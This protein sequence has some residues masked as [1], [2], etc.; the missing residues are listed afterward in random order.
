M[1][2]L[3]EKYVEEMS[4]D[5]NSISLAIYEFYSNP[6]ISKEDHSVKKQYEI[7]KE[8]WVALINYGISTHEFQSVDPEAII[9]ARPTLELKEKALAYRDH[10]S[11]AYIE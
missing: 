4:D 9:L 11:A 7:S 6:E 1:E 2:E 8:T 3:L 5:E 10:R